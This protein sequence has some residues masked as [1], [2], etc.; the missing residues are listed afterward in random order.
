MLEHIV[1]CHFEVLL[2]SLA[3]RDCDAIKN[4]FWPGIVKIRIQL[5]RYSL[6]VVRPTRLVEV[7]RTGIIPAGIDVR[8]SFN[9][10][11]V[12]SRNCLLILR[13]EFGA[14]IEIDLDQS[15]RE[16]LHQ[17]ACIVLVG[18]DIQYRIGL[19]IT[20]HAEVNT[21]C[22]MQG[23]YVHKVAIVAERIERQLIV[24]IADGI[25]SQGEPADL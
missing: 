24:I 8:K 2:A 10:G 3:G 1:Q 7:W 18:T 17:L 13:I 16:Q 19:L 4:R 22:R 6:V 20:Q 21:H 23:H 5:H 12:V 14:A 11:L 9:Y 25:R 15:D